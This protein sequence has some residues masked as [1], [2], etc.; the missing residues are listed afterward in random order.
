MYK[1]PYSCCNITTH[2]TKIISLT[3]LW[4]YILGQI[5]D[6]LLTL[7]K[8]LRTVKISR[9]RIMTFYP[10]KNATEMKYA[11]KMILL[12]VKKKLFH[13]I[14]RCQ[15]KIFYVTF[16][17]LIHHIS[18]LPQ[19]KHILYL[20]LLKIYLYLLCFVHVIWSIFFL[21]F[22]KQITNIGLFYIDFTK[23]QLLHRLTSFRTIFLVSY[24]IWLL[25]YHNLLFCLIFE[26]HIF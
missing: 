16:F 6:M 24:I 1:I 12:A 23:I 11:T 3:L 18:I 8:L 22:W 2:I 10:S 17:T 5:N 19:L 14:S 20:I 4:W 15:P 21:F 26:V 13:C 25:R 9:R 7:S